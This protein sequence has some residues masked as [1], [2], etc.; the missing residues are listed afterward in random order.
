[1]VSQ[2]P[3]KSKINLKLLRED[4]SKTKPIELRVTATLGELPK[5]QLALRGG[6]R[7]GREPTPTRTEVLDSVTVT[8]IDPRVRRQFQIPDDL[9]GAL[10]VEV[11]PDSAA[12]EGGLRPG[13]VILEIN[14]QKVRDAQ[15]ATDISK[16]ARNGRVLLRAWSKGVIHFLV[17]EQPKK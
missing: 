11:A 7:G 1:M 16:K 2:T 4:K 9:R 10:V 6:G 14:K 12:Y 15:A 17:V 8:D 3:P 13:D 5:E